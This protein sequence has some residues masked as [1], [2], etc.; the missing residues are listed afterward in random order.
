MQNDLGQMLRE[1]GL[2][3]TAQRLAILRAVSARPHAT[4]DDLIQHVRTEIG[5]ISRQAVYDSLRVLTDKQ[6]VRRIQPAGSPGLYDPRVG[7]TY[8]GQRTATV[9][10]GV[11]KTRAADSVAPSVT[12]PGGK[13]TD[14]RV[15]RGHEHRAAVGS[16][17]PNL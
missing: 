16:P 2:Q 3:V 9:R 13:T 4:A 12:W 7:G 1:N 17:R 10:L 5:T 15:R 6:L 8:Q 14:H 11:A